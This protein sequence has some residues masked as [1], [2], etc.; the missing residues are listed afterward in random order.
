MAQ[1]TAW[2]GLA[3]TSAA[4][5]APWAGA[6]PA[7]PYGIT[8]QWPAWGV[9]RPS[10]TMSAPNTP[11]GVEPALLSPQGARYWSRQGGGHALLGSIARAHVVTGTLGV[12]LG[13][14]G[15]LLLMPGSLLPVIAGGAALLALLAGAVALELAQFSYPATALGARILLV[16]ADLLAAGCVLW[17]F[18]GESFAMALF[19]APIVLAALFFSGRTAAAISALAVAGFVAI[20]A[21]QAE[22]TTASWL[23]WAG[24]LAGISALLVYCCTLAPGQTATGFAG[25]FQWVEQL[26]GQ[27]AALRAEQQRLIEA[28]RLLEDA[29]SRLS[30]E[31]AIINRQTHEVARVVERLSEGDANALRALHPGLQGPLMA[32]S[33]SLTSIGQRLASLQSQQQQATTQQRTVEAVYGTAREQGQLLGLTDSA[34]R[35]L[36]A[37]ANELVAMVQRMEHGGELFSLDRRSIIQAL[38][39]VEQQALTQ[40]SNTAM[41]GARLAQLRARQSEIESSMRQMARGAS[42][43]A[44]TAG[45]PASDRN[46]VSGPQAAARGSEVPIHASI[47]GGQR[48]EPVR[49]TSGHQAN[50][51]M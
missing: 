24:A 4:E 35:E 47:T 21:A 2:Q 1:R 17:L 6:G 19:F 32:L 38:R 39:E 16:G 15:W 29:Q 5:E 7:I 34:L 9:S 40:A 43:P 25:V 36:S 26:A 50:W 37:S 23:P 11:D 44:D 41:L 42:A 30:Q 49:S 33:G 14:L 20:C 28:M 13:V 18:G 10:R 22:F 3:M 46:A 45:G 48:L 51:L 8:Q 31:R 27:R 12:T